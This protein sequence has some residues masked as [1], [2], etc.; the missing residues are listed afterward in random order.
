MKFTQVNKDQI[1]QASEAIETIRQLK[2]ILAEQR[3]FNKA[4]G[5]YFLEQKTVNVSI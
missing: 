1:E 3:L 5:K 4:F 2:R